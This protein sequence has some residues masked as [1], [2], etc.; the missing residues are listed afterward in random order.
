MKL[1][2]G[3]Y[4][5]KGILY[6]RFQDGHGEICRESTHQ[7]SIRIAEEILAKRKTEV[8]EGRYFP[9]RQFEKVIFAELTDKWWKGHGQYTRSCFRFLRGRIERQFGSMRAR[10][11]EVP[12][13]RTFF[14]ELERRGYS[15]AY[16]NSH[17]TMLNSIFNYTIRN[18]EYD[19]SPVESIPQ[20][21]ERERTRL[22][23][24]EEWQRLLVACEG[25]PELRCFVI[26]A[27]VTR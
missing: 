16:I 13:I 24:L 1:P 20:L 5:R 21:R 14:T 7:S 11:V 15:P 8:A 19:R 6:I 26:L 2:R 25:D 3:I 23:T 18:R 17:R 27:A 9:A 22:V 10:D 4:E 12:A